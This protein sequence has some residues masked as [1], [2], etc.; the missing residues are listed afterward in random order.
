MKK[1]TIVG[2]GGI[3]GILGAVLIRQYGEAVSL[4]ARGKRAEALRR[5]GLTLLSPLFGDFTVHPALVSNDPRDY[6]TQD[7]IFV[8]VK[9]DGLAAAAE[10]IRPLVGPE[11]VVVPVM[12]GVSAAE[13]LR[14][15]LPG[16]LV[17]ACVIYT[18]AIAG[19]NGAVS[20]VGRFCRVV[21]GAP[22]DD[23]AEKKTLEEAAALLSACGI[24]AEVSS[25]AEKAVWEKYILNCGYNVVT[26]RWGCTIG[27]VKASPERTEDYRQLLTEALRVGQARG[28]ALSDSLVDE[29]MDRLLHTS[30]KATSSLSRDF[31]I[32]KKGELEIFC[33]EVV[34]MGEQCGVETPVTK[35]YYEAMLKIA[36]G[37]SGR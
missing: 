9:N 16:T 25:D 22:S 18:V 14:K 11:T 4:F 27:D 28:V 8:C 35:A 2:V 33:G 3:G 13:N 7:L 20:Q 12:N 24:Q 30:G 15:L 19:E 32:G 10:E 29:L 6:E 17:P 1:I 26:A 31:A 23:P 5:D 21:M 34:R 37:F 36:E